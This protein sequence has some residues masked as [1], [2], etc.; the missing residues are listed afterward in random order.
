M[1]KQAD[2]PTDEPLPVPE[3][4]AGFVRVRHPDLNA[5]ADIPVSALSFHQSRGWV[6]D[7][8]HEAS[9]EAVASDPD[10]KET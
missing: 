9:P 10:T 1:K 8:P 4:I 3:P 5:T 7:S 2:I 6:L